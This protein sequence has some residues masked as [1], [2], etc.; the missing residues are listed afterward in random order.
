MQNFADPTDELA[1]RAWV[2]KG[3]RF[4]AHRRLT[5]RHAW[6]T[7]AIAVLSVYIIA[8]SLFAQFIASTVISPAVVTAGLIIAS[9]L[10]LVLSLIESGRSY[11][12]RADHLH[13]C[14]V[15]LGRLELKCVEVA[16]LPISDIRSVSTSRLA[17]RY[18]TIIRVCPDNHDEIDFATFRLQHP[19][20]YPLAL[21]TRMYIRFRRELVT[22][23]PY[24]VA[25]ALPPLIV[26]LFA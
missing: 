16:A 8:A 17:R 7:W 4:A 9:V 12:L 19:E 11:Q 22:V 13:Q 1:R 23:G 25:M 18:S 10:V 3:A 21:H 15:A 5:R 26:C 14:A 20:Q 6:S 24:L 2:T